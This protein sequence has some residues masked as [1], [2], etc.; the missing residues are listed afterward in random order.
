MIRQAGR[1]S[2]FVVALGLLGLLLSSCRVGAS[3]Q[4]VSHR[5]PDGVDLYFKVPPRWAIF[6]TDQVVEAQNGKLGPT[7]LKQIAN[8]EWVETM[9]PRPGVTPKTSLGIGKRYPT[10][11][12]ETRP[13]GQTER[14]SLNFSTMRSEL[15]GTD[16]LTATSGFQVLSYHEFALSGGI[17]GIKM[18][19][20]ITGTSPVLTF[21]QVTAVD[22]ATNYIFAVGAGCQASCW[23][24]NAS[25]VTS[26]LNS[27]TL[28]EQ[29][30]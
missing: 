5:A 14:D 28:K 18:I 17:H 8:G 29:A 2:L 11:V 21:G 15:L 3:F 7:Q 12:V 9:S 1:S 6:G 4:Y 23:G 16:P 24:A 26:L 19:V 27:W 25:A 20:N 22:A 13:L 30:P 10:A